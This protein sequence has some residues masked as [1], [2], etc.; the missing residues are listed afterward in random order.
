MSCMLAVNHFTVKSVDFLAKSS[1]EQDVCLQPDLEWGGCEKLKS[2]SIE[3]QKLEGAAQSQS[4]VLTLLPSVLCH[5][6]L[7]AKI[8]TNTAVIFLRVELHLRLPWPM[9]LRKHER[10]CPQKLRLQCTSCANFPNHKD[11]PW[12]MATVL[13][14]FV[15]RPR[16][17]LLGS[18]EWLSWFIRGRI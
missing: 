16:D 17:G 2:D 14:F 3:I 9:S 13:F 11:G 15:E 18:G 6:T 12:K 4:S 1:P 8:D 5:P 10:A 7:R